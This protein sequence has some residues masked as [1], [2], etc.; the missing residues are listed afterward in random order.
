MQMLDYSSY[1]VLLVD[2]ESDII[3][4]LAEEFGGIGFYTQCANGVKAAL[5]LLSERAFDVII[6]DYRMPDGDGLQILNRLNQ[7]KHNTHFYFI[8]GQADI[9]PEVALNYGAKKFYSKP[10]DIEELINQV[11]DNLAV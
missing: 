3:E 11:K 5:K 7:Q 9:H 6:S 10:F 8:S 2:D 1:S 4:Y